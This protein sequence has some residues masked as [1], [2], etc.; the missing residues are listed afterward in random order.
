MKSFF[1]SGIF[2][3]FPIIPIFAQQKVSNTILKEGFFPKKSEAISPYF[4]TLGLNVLDNGNSKLPF[5]ADEWSIT[6]PFFISLERRSDGSDFSAV[7]SFSTNKLKIKSINRFYY[8]IDASARYY[9]DDLIFNNT[10]IET[11][12]GL[13]LGRFFLENNGNNT[14]NFSGGGRYWFSKNFALSLEAIGK[15]GLKPMNEAVLNHYA[16]N[17]GIVW[18]TSARKKILEETPIALEES[19]IEEKEK[20][21]ALKEDVIKD[22]EVVVSIMES[23]IKDKE[24]VVALKENILKAKEE[25]ESKSN[26]KEVPKLPLSEVKTAEALVSKLSNRTFPDEIP[27]RLDYTGDWYIRITNSE[28]TSLIFEH[29]LFSTYSSSEEDGTMWISDA[30]K[31]PWLQCKISVN[32]K[33]GTFTALAQ[34]NFL[35]QGTL[36]ITEGRFENRTGVSKAGNIV[37]KIYFKAEFSY[38]PGNILLFEGHKSTGLQVD[39]Y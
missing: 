1:L 22:K 27:T 9:F 24:K 25:L 2:L 16:Y 23:V 15:V 10:D 32:L 7:L 39:K 29:A 31:G 4:L 33:E 14:L 28:K 6:N 34:P 17:F 18:G 20:V 12:A 35:D 11:Y 5:N 21:V 8:S 19:L 3:L 37:D 26:E 13:G 38:D 30:K 36:T